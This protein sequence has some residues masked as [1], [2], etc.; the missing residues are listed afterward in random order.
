MASRASQNGAGGA[1][2]AGNGAGGAGG[3]GNGAGGAGGAGNG[4]GGNGNVSMHLSTSWPSAAIFLLTHPPD[5]D[6]S[7]N[8]TGCCTNLSSGVHGV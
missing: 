2:G 5:A 6:L 8:Y 4:A 3:A 1:G 7:S